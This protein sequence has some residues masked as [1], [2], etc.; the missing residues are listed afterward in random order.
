MTKIKKF[1]FFCLSKPLISHSTVRPIFIQS[2]ALHFAQFIKKNCGI[3]KFRISSNHPDL[4]NFANSSLATIP[5][6]E[7]GL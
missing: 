6:M 4:I 1:S 3:T 2:S 5:I 7:V